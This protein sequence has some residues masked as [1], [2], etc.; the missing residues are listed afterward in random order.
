MFAALPD[1]TSLAYLLL[2][3]LAAGF[4]TGFAG[5]GTGL[6]ASGFWFHVLPPVVVPPLVVMA[7][8]A[9]QGVS[10]LSVRPRFDWRR[11]APYLIG[12]ALGVPFGV[13]ALTV[14][15][16]DLLR[17][18]AGIFLIAYAASQLTGLTRLRVA[19]WGGRPADAAI[20]VGG[21]VLGGFAGLSGPLPLIWLQLR[22]GPSLDQRAVYQPFNLIILALAAA[23][24]GVAGQIDATVLQSLVIAVPATA[25]GATLG[26]RTYHR[27]SEATFRR[28][29]LALLLVSGVMLVA[30]SL[31]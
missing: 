21:G 26:A 13:L 30:Q 29:V 19:A 17:L 15:S 28:I 7:S 16:P 24:M 2:G 12:G 4:V 20:G 25:I 9:A 1:P 23:G 8:V 10:L 5:F 31:R 14:T 11:A 18:C 6:V 22:G 27:A 3:A